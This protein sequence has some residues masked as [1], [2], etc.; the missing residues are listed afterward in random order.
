MNVLLTG[1]TGFVGEEFAKNVAKKHRVWAIYR[2]SPGKIVNKVTW[3]KADLICETDFDKL[4]PELKNKIDVVVHVGGATPNRA[5]R[6]NSFAATTEGTK[7]LVEFA[8]KIG[9]KKIIF[10]STVSI[11]IEKPGPYAKSKLVA[12]KII[13]ES[14]LKYVI[15]RPGTI[16]GPGAVDFNRIVKIIKKTSILPMI[17]PDKAMVQ[18]IDIDD[19]VDVMIRCME[20]DWWEGKEFFAIGAEALSLREFI[21]I[22][23]KVY[24]HKIKIVSVPKK[25]AISVAKIAERI[26]PRWGLNE[27]RIYMQSYDKV[28]PSEDAMSFGIRLKSFKEMIQ[29]LND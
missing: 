17:D 3:T 1:G 2:N 27:E 12:E 16:I 7:I 28:I 14:G 6:D 20:T 19:L 21:N 5:Y 15:I 29:Y 10:V 22:I 4:V 8:K 23:A 18:P 9:V 13:K 25:L 11:L 26:N 24:R